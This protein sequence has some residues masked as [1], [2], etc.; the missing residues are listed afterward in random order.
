M[1]KVANQD[2]GLLGNDLLTVA[3]AYGLL[4]ETA[5]LVFILNLF[6]NYYYSLF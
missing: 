1:R 2:S 4:H 6:S 5:I 3:Q